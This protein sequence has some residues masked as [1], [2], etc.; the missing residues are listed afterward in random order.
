MADVQVEDGYTRVAHPILEALAL[1]PFNASQQKL[2]L[3]VIRITYG[4]NRR[5]CELSY[6]AAAKATGLARSSVGAALGELVSEGVLEMISEPGFRTPAS[7]RLRK[8]PRTWGRFACCPPSLPPPVSGQPDSTEAPDY[9]GQPDSPPGRTVRSEPPDSTGQP[10]TT[11]PAS[12][13]VRS[14]KPAPA[15]GS[16]GPKDSERKERQKNPTQL[17]RA[18]AGDRAKLVE[19]LGADEQAKAAVEAMDTSAPHTEL[20]AANVSALY[21]RSPSD[22]LVYRG[23]AESD[24]PPILRT[25]LLRYA[26]TDQPYAGHFFRRILTTVISE[27]RTP[28]EGGDGNSSDGARGTRRAARGETRAKPA[29]AGGRGRVRF[30]PEA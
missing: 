16:E 8:D 12:R 15:L 3:H 6:S 5:D 21:G 30:S 7:Y 11:V 24:R 13:T 27:Q 28:L 1:A 25:A 29:G 2:M 26:G 4:W 14:S 17:P 23:V 20:W 10:D 22:E 9:T 18:R 19:F